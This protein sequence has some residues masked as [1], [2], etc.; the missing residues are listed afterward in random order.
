MAAGEG[1]LALD[2]IVG[3]GGC[4]PRRGSGA[5]IAPTGCPCNPPGGV[6]PLPD[7][8]GAISAEGGREWDREPTPLAPATPVD[9]AEPLE[10]VKPVEA[11]RQ[12][13][14]GA[15]AGAA[16]VSMICMR[17][18]MK[19]STNISR[20]VGRAFGSLESMLLTRWRSS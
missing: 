14:E 9:P 13:E 16:G 20:S 19:G 8:A 18:R 5:G 3:V 4:G 1:V 2:A 7:E 6:W 11:A 10:L 17:S 15:A 12:L